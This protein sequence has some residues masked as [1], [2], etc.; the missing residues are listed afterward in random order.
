MTISSVLG[1]PAGLVP[2]I[3]PCWRRLLWVK[4]GLILLLLVVLRQF[5]QPVVLAGVLD[6]SG[7]IP[8]LVVSFVKPMAFSR[9]FVVLVPAVLPVL[10][11]QFGALNLNRLGRG[12]AIGVLGLL[13]ASWWGPG[14]SELDPA[15]RG[16]REQ[17]Q[18]RLIS[19]RTGGL[20]ERY[21]PRARLLNLSDQMEVAMGRIP[22]DPVPWGDADD[23]EKRLAAPPLPS[24]LWL[25]K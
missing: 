19:Q 13:L 2:R 1:Q 11:V 23:L 8:S 3:T 25:A 24:E 9:Y 4:L 10:A 7:L 12:C 14:F 16:V 6:R 5:E 20:G 22:S 18:F 21:G 15:L 17:D